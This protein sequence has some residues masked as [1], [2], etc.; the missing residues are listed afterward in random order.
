MIPDVTV[1]AAITESLARI[2]AQ[3][4]QIL[5]IME[6]VGKVLEMAQSHPMLG[7][8]IGTPGR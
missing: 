3:N 8:F 2:E 6:S 4:A 7:A 1:E 5:A